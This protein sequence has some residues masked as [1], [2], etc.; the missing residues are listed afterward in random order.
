MFDDF[1]Q[2]ISFLIYC[3]RSPTYSW[4]PFALL[5]GNKS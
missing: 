1:L 3:T 5:D 4:L 2:K